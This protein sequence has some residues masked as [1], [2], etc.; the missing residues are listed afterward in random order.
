MPSMPSVCSRDRGNADA[1]TLV[2]LDG[3]EGRGA[4]IFERGNLS[5]TCPCF[6]G[7]FLNEVLICAGRIN[8]TT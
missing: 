7:F 4:A 8:V 5:P 2:L 1:I 3:F 6:K